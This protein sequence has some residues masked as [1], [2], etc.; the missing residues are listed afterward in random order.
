MTEYRIEISRAVQ[1]TI[2]HLPPELKRRVRT[3]FRALAINPYQAKALK[4]DLTGLRSYR[5]GTARIILRIAGEVVEVVA[6][7]PRRDICK[8]VVAE[9]SLSFPAKDDTTR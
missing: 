1:A 4:D 3:A 9:L 8:R 6:F 7:G 5:L 2:T